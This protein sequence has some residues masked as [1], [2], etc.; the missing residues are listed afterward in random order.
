MAQLDRPHITSY[1][2]SV[3]I[4]FLACTVCKILPHLQCTLTLKSPSLSTQ[5]LKLHAKYA[6]DSSVN[7]SWLIR[8]IFPEVLE[9]ER[10]QTPK[11]TF[12][13]TQGHRYWCYLIN[14][15]YDFLL[16]FHCITMSLFYTIS[17]TWSLIYRNL[18]THTLMLTTINLDTNSE[19]P[20]FTRFKEKMG[21][22]I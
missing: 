1:Y 7:I 21:P 8:T 9:L 17:E 11:M 13:V 5:Q 16:V 18:K 3:V 6:F 10:L 19:V 15:I 20:S 2:W 22:K 14:H 4:M 12:K